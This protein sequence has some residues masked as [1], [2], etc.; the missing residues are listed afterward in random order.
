MAISM[1]M[2]IRWYGAERRAHRPVR[3]VQGYPRCHW[4]PPSDDYSPRI[5][6][7][8]AMVIDFGGGGEGKS[9][10]GGNEERIKGGSQ[11]TEEGRSQRGLTTTKSLA[12][13]GGGRR[14]EEG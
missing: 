3:Q 5:A 12:G 9:S 13:D 14:Q 1:A 6:P 10:P 2:R 11:Q 8:D 4:T 7:A